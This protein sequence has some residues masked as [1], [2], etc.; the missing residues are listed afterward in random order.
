MTKTPIDR[1]TRAEVKQVTVEKDRVRI[2]FYGGRYIEIE[3]KELEVVVN[4]EVYEQTG[5]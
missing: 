2:D 3:G 1:L 4:G 5:N